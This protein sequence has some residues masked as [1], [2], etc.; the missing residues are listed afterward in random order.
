MKHFN[1]IQSKINQTD[2]NC[3]SQTI[4]IQLQSNL[5]K[6]QVIINLDFLQSHLI[7][8]ISIANQSKIF[9]HSSVIRI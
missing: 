1:N 6:H 9:S 2:S 3:I 5:C 8:G 4:F 7:E